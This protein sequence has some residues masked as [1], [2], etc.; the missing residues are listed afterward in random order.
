M[1]QTT[2]L[3]VSALLALVPA[4]LLPFRS[5]PK[6]D[7][8]YWLLLAVAAVGPIV[9]LAAVFAPGWRTGLSPSL[10]ITLAVTLLIFTALAAATREA[11]R[12]TPLLLPYLLLVG[13]VAAVWQHQPER[14]TLGTA[15][16]AWIEFHILVSVIAYGLVTIAAVA[17]LAVFLQERALK[18]KRPSALTRLLP[19]VADS[20]EL[21]VRLLAASAAVLAI[22][23]LSGMTTQYFET[24][25]VLIFTHKIA[26]TI[27]AFI[28]L[29]GLVWAH[30]KTGMRGRRAA[31]W[32]LLA[33]LLLSLA[34][35]GVKFVTDVMLA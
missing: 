31:R 29:L 8:I 21:Q 4:S 3:A 16:S 14:P 33:W 25:A 13:V 7:A 17:G 28:V 22:G 1:T 15:P 19:S 12:L 24:G 27:L 34:Y 6:R 5:A 35:P 10:I 26:F 9:W 20:E 23:I 11:W 18:S 30:Y 32:L 2:W